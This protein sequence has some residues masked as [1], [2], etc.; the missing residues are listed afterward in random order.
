LTCNPIEKDENVPNAKPTKCCDCCPEDCGAIKCFCNRRILAPINKSLK[1]ATFGSS[2]GMIAALGLVLSLV[3]SGHAE[4]AVAGGIA[5]TVGETISMGGAEW[6]SEPDNHRLHRTVTM[7]VASAIGCLTPL[8]PLF[9]G[10][11]VW[12]GVPCATFGI[13]I[14]ALLRPESTFRVW[15]STMAVLLPAVLLSM[16]ATTWI[17]EGNIHSITHFV[18]HLL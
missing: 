7:A 17:E 14:L 15:L 8:M 10:I 12:W 13:F 5:V 2:G 3:V 1:Q 9:L 4:A 16:I 11:P 18:T 6:I